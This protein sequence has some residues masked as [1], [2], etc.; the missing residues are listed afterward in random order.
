MTSLFQSHGKLRTGRTILL[1]AVAL[2]VLFPA[3][4]W[5]QLAITTTALPVGNTSNTYTATLAAT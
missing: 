4:A 2:S 3:M 1:V 5:A